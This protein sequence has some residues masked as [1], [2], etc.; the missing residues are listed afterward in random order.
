MKKLLI[1][2]LF[3]LA[4]AG[5]KAQQVVVDPGHIAATIANGG[6]L[7]KILNTMDDINQVSLTISNTVNDIRGLQHNIDQALWKVKDLIK[8]DLGFGDIQFELEAF[9][10]LS[11]GLEPY[12]NMF[13]ADHPLIKGYR[14]ISTVLGSQMLHGTLDLILKNKSPS[15][16]RNIKLYRQTSLS[17]G[18]L[19]IMLLPKRSFR[20]H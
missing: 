11:P 9:Q 20:L 2:I 17:A 16:N 8:D 4:G 14:N 15:V 1:I 3:H 19:T 6:V 5:I 10:N 18:R 13:S 7:T 12:L